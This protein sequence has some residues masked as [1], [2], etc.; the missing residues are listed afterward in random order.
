MLEA[1][2]LDNHLL[3]LDKP[4]GMPTVPDSSGDESLLEHAKALLKREFRK[5]GAVY[6]GVVHRLDRPVSGIVLFARTSKAA[7]RVSSAF[8]ERRV[9]KVYW[10]VSREAPGPTEGV[11]EHWLWKDTARNRVMVVS[12]GAA[13]AKRARTRWRSLASSGRGDE[14]RVLVELVPETGRPHQLRAAM[15]ALGAPLLGDLKY[16]ATA[17]LPDASIA[18]HA[19]RLVV[20]HPVRPGVV[21]LDAPCPGGAVW[22]FPGIVGA[23]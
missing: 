21:E 4:A 19:K 15:A 2:Y 6:L 10:G 20:P 1:L 13:G 9:E 16:G 22:R 12:A 17:A 5:P 18:L 8:R 3:A 23:R 11:L 7:E 14:R